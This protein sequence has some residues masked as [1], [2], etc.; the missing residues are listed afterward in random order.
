MNA[1]EGEITLKVAGEKLQHSSRKAEKHGPPG[2][3]PS[4][5]AIRKSRRRPSTFCLLPLHIIVEL[6]N[7]HNHK[8]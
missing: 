6:L 1:G 7:N 8:P 4:A 5:R 2:A 3:S